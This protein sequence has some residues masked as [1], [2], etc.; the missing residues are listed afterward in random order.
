MFSFVLFLLIGL[1]L[2][3]AVI[4][5]F[6]LRTLLSYFL[7]IFLQCHGTPKPFLNRW[8]KTKTKKDFVI[9][10]IVFTVCRIIWVPYFLYQTYAIHLKR[11]DWLLYPSIA[12]MV[13][14]LA[15][16]AKACKMFVNY[17]VPDDN[18]GGG[19]T[20][21][22]KEIRRAMKEPGKSGKKKKKGSYEIPE[23]SK[24]SYVYPN[25]QE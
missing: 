9:F 3:M 10:F 11:I 1:L 23:D 6:H 4:V 19:R 12:F 16:Y 20:M 22:K 24:V 21:S 17:K 5:L 7:F 13:L 25:K 18:V 15:W 14:Q 2:F 8:K